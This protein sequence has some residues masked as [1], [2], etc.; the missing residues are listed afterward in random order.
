MRNPRPTALVLASLL[1]M[2][3]AS[4]CQAGEED[5]PGK[6]F[7]RL[8]SR[9]QFFCGGEFL[10]DSPPTGRVPTDMLADYQKLLDEVTAPK[11]ETSA[12]LALLKHK[13]PHVRTLAIAALYAKEDPKLLPRLDEMCNDS[14]ATYPVP[15]PFPFDSFNSTQDKLLP[16]E[17]RKVGRL[18]AVI[19]GKYLELAGERDFPTYWAA[20]TERSARRGSRSNSFA[21]ARATGRRREILSRE[22]GR[23][24]RG[25][26][27]CRSQTCAWTL[28]WLRKE[29]GADAM[30]TEQDLLAACKDLG[31]DRLLAMLRRKIPSDD[32][33]L[34]VRRMNNWD[35]KSLQLFVLARAEKLLCRRTA[36]ALI[37]CDKSEWDFVKNR[38]DDPTFTSWWAVAAAHLQPEHAK[39][40]LH[41]AMKRYN[42]YYLDSHDRENI[43]AALWELVGP[44]ETDFLVNWFYT[45][46]PERGDYPGCRAEFLQTVSAQRGRVGRKLIAEIVRDKR[47]DTLEWR[48]LRTVIDVVNAWVD[49]PVVEQAAIDNLKPPVNLD[50]FYWLQAEAREQHPKKTAAL[51]KTFAEWATALRESIPKWGE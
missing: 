32:P 36:P 33:D 37:E 40:W 30:V 28:L 51:L 44:D 5:A 22:S 14:A 23:C 13:D 1:G 31:P 11:H 4:T 50:S 48:T 38:I 17:E 34:Q 42:G 43:A 27:G 21:R 47:L 49:K 45:Q 24:E 2:V 39:E 18:A 7:E 15:Q 19:V 6:D 20:R 3:L 25:S 29:R 9:F 35:Y 16:L 26:T 46:K 12:L 10:Y 41:D 8:A